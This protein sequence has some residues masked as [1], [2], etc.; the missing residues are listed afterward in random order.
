M[1]IRHNLPSKAFTKLDRYVF[2]RRG[3]SDGAKVLYGYLCGLRNGANFSDKYIL[4][5]MDISQRALTNRKKE[6]KEAD[7]ILMEQVSARIYVIYI[8]HTKMSARQ[9]KAQWK[10]EEDLHNKTK[11]EAVK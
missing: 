6:L 7:L 4:G 9:V 5:A 2:T 8:G 11:L 1:I 10:R 3:L